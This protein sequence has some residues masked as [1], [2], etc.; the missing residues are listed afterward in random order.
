MPNFKRILPSNNQELRVALIDGLYYLF[1]NTT[2]NMHLYL[3]KED[4][5]DFIKYPNQ[6]EWGR[7]SHSNSIAYEDYEAIV[8]Y[9]KSCEKKYNT[10]TDVLK[11]RSKYKEKYLKQF[12]I[13]ELTEY[14]KQKEDKVNVK[15]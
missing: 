15:T 2:Y 9:L 8:K 10:I 12:T 3:Y 7:L 4:I 13:G 14:I 1:E 11:S 5:E 6:R